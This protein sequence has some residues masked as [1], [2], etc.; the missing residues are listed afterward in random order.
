MGAVESL[1]AL[2]VAVGLPL[3]GALV[4]L[5][6]PRAAFLV[7]GMGTRRSRGCAASRLTT[8]T[9]TSG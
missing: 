8:G 1:A 5:S 7:V 2:S 4:A 6:S 3:G 9:N